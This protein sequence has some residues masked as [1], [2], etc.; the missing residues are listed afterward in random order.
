MSAVHVT[1]AAVVEVRGEFLL[2]EEE[3]D[4]GVRFNQP[5]GHLEP[6]E[7]IV[8]AAIR[9]TLE[10]TAYRFS[11]AALI[12]IYRWQRAEKD[13]TYVRFA[14]SGTVTG[15]EPGR[16]LD[17]GIVR[18]VWQPLESI[19]AGTALHRSPLVLQCVEDYLSGHRYPLALL[20]DRD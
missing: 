20:I 17:A 1:V 18:A 5:A 9:E 4:D 8:D 11:P 14:F 15:P 7:S 12:G 10:E 19:R 16:A 3:T 6:G 2:V 13:L